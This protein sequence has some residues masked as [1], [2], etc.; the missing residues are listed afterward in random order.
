MHSAWICRQCQVPLRYCRCAAKGLKTLTQ[1]KDDAKETDTR[2][3][4]QTEINVTSNLTKKQ[5][6]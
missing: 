3:Q 5:K 1:F 2:F 6:L 4:A